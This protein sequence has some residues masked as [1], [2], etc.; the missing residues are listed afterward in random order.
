M[1]IKYFFQNTSPKLLLLTD[2]TFQYPVGTAYNTCIYLFIS[3]LIKLVVIEVLGC[4]SNNNI[5]VNAMAWLT[6]KTRP[7]KSYQAK[8]SRSTSTDLGKS[9]RTSKIGERW[10]PVPLE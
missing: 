9:R 6:H 5:F 10:G 3:F 1:N 7:H 2:D 8:F 4:N